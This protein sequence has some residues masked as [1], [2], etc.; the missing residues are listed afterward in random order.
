MSLLVLSDIHMSASKPAG[1]TGDYIADVDAKLHEVADLARE[2]KVEAVLCAG[3]IFHRS[4]PTLSVVARFLT[5]LEWLDIRFITIPGSH[6]LVGNN[7]DVLYRTAIGLLDRLGL[8][9]LLTPVT[10]DVT[11]VGSFVIG[12]PY[13]DVPDIKLVHESI[14]PEPVF[15]EYTLLED[16]EARSRIVI[17]GHEHSGYDLKTIGDTTY[18]CPGSLVRTIARESEL[19]RRPRVA[20]IHE[21]YNVE[22]CELQVAKPGHEVLAPPVVTPEVDFAGIVKEWASVKIEEID[23]T[24]LLREVAEEEKVS[25]EVV[26]YALAL[27][28]DNDG[29]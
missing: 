26:D 2:I 5:F 23:V 10:K 7:L 4:A 11:R 1:R 8:I 16:Y 3:D 6:D 13:V 14:V 20:I 25:K 17:V 21:D 15:G 18:V 24:V 27:L 9:E 19:D 22:W 12:S 29:V 28:G